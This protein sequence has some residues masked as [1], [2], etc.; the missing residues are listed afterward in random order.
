MTNVSSTALSRYA[1]LRASSAEPGAIVAALGA[2]LDRV[3]L[4]R[5]TPIDELS[6]PPPRPGA[7]DLL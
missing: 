4:R 7:V 2:A 3:G 1:G 6:A 5:H